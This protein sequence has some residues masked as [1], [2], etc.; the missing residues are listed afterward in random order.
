MT[1]IGELDTSDSELIE[2]KIGPLLTYVANAEM[3]P[4]SGG[5][6]RTQ[7]PRRFGGVAF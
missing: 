1:I 3:R 4:V 7:G 5:A 2:N 6:E